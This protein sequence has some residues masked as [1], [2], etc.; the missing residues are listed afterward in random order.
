MSPVSPGCPSHRAPRSYHHTCIRSQA[1]MGGP[2]WAGRKRHRKATAGS[3]A[4]NWTQRRK[5]M[6]PCPEGKGCACQQEVAYDRDEAN[7]GQVLA[8]H[9]TWHLSRRKALLGNL[10]CIL[11]GSETSAWP[12]CFAVPRMDEG[13]PCGLP[14]V[15]SLLL[16]AAGLSRHGPARARN[17][18]VWS[19]FQPKRRHDERLRGYGTWPLSHSRTLSISGHLHLPLWVSG[20]AAQSAPSPSADNCVETEKNPGL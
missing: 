13:G 18:P 5:A 1:D 15:L 9:C 8:L 16:N 7:D 14:A 3:N 10:H 17:F 6:R 2:Y 19:R 20:T 11:Q 12:P 4:R